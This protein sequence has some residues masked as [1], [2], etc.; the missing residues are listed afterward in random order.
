MLAPPYVP[1][2]LQWSRVLPQEII[3]VFVYPVSED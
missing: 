3:L 1:S 2:M